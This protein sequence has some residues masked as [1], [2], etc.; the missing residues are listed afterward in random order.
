MLPHLQA[1]DIPTLINLISRGNSYHCD[2]HYYTWSRCDAALS[3]RLWDC[4]GSC[5]LSENCELAGGVKK[6]RN[7]NHLFWL[8]YTVCHGWA[9]QGRDWEWGV[10][11][12]ITWLHDTGLSTVHPTQPVPGFLHVSCLSL[13]LASLPITPI[14]RKLEH[15]SLIHVMVKKKNEW[16]K[17]HSLANINFNTILDRGSI[18]SSPRYS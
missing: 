2:D 4:F 18:R 15:L 7:I 12:I 3:H 11:V 10:K 14:R 16:V 8:Q 1:G 6:Y 9:S 13:S 17:E 5:P